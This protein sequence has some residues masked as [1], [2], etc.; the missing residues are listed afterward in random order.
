VFA[1]PGGLAERGGIGRVVSSVARAWGARADEL[2]L[3]FVDPYGPGGSLRSPRYLAAA[4]ARIA[5]GASRGRIALLHVNVATRGSVLRKAAVAALGARLGLPLVVHLHGNDPDAFFPRLP[6]PAARALGR[7]FARAERVLVLGEP[8]RRFAIER[9]ELDPARVR[10]L[11]NA[12]ALPERDP[13]APDSKECRLLFLGR[14]DASKGLPELLAALAAPQLAGLAWRARAAGNGPVQRWRAAADGLAARLALEPWQPEAT[15]R[16]WLAQSDV[17]V[18]PSRR[19][20]LPM[21]LLEAMAFGR[22]VI[23]T[24]VGCVPEVI[25]HGRT[26]LLVPP[27][28]APALARTLARVIADPALRSALGARARAHARAHHEIG[29]YCDRLAALYREVLSERERRR[30]VSLFFGSAG[31]GPAG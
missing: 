23:A 3:G 1:T 24:P 9:L 13:P 27:G 5:Q 21:A 30:A 6:R 31:S 4:L 25:E 19:E 10:V 7:A 15:V 14:L 16:G 11:P 17:L 2:P 26:G 20:G 18:L 8:W 28:D 12:V 22:C 29:A